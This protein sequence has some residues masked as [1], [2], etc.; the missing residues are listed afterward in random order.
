MQ[1]PLDKQVA[2]ITGASKGIGKATALKLAS[3]GA[4]VA[5]MARSADDLAKVAAEAELAGVRTLTF[6]VDVTND[7]AVERALQVAMVKLGS[8]S[9]LVNGAGTAPPRGSHG[10]A[11]IAE[12]D[13]ML[14]TCLRAPMVLSRL[15]LPDMLVHGRGCIINIASVAA[16]RARPGEAAYSAAKAGLLAFSHSLF[17]EVRNSGIKVVAVC[18]GYVNTDFIP[19]NR[20]MDRAKFLQPDDV[21]EAIAQ[22]VLSPVHA[23]V[24]EII[25]EPQLEQDSN[26]AHA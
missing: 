1:K 8:V 24:S 5:L 26:P 4:S 12:W 22:A 3:L 18:P 20:K 14:A 17:R 7:E 19:A 13:R 9:I 25:L 15:L 11:A 21:A 2:L 6:P 23:C 16:R 10:K